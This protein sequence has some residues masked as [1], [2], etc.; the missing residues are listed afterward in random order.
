MVANY[1][2][3]SH[4]QNQQKVASDNHEAIL[5]ALHANEDIKAYE[6]LELHIQGACQKIIDQ[7]NCK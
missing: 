7:M 3:T 4:T 1:L 6:R 5:H 2:L